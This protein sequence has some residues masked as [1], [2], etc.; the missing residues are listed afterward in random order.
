M[1]RDWKVG[2]C[3]VTFIALGFL[4]YALFGRPPYAFFS[5]MKLT[6]ASSALAG[7]WALFRESKRYIPV[8]F[9]LVLIAG[10]HLSARMRRS[11]WAL[12]DWGAV[13]GLAVLLLILLSHLV[14]EAKAQIR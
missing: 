1:T 8:S 4:A 11:E 13:A 7:A 10:T 14:R 2:I 3:G 12:F 6:V 5:V 9:Y